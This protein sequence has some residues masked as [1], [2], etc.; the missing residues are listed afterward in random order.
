MKHFFLFFA[1]IVAC[2]VCAGC[3]EGFL[4]PYSPSEYK[5]GEYTL[6]VA[7]YA[8]DKAAV[9]VLTFDD[10]TY[11]QYIHAV[12]ALEER[13]LPGTFFINGTKVLEET[14]PSS[15]APGQK[16]LKD[17]V[18]RGFEVSNHTFHHARLTDISLDSAR[19]EIE[20]N[21]SCIE[22]WTG[23]RPVTFAFPYNARNAK[24]VALAGERRVGVR[25]YETGFGQ[26]YRTTTYQEMVDWAKRAVSDHSIAVAMYHGIEY[27]YD[28][29][30]NPNELMRFWDYLAASEDIWVATFRDASAYRAER[31]DVELVAR[32]ERSQLLIEAKTKL[33]TRLFNYPLTVLVKS[34]DTTMKVK[35][36]P[37]ERVSVD[38][39]TNTR[40]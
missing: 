32:Q 21:D 33:D 5:V 8:D 3:S 18:E 20:M 15:N 19:A 29:W 34:K 9:V 30:N 31:D 26:T 2:A 7:K 14:R 17:M 38:V 36:K 27:G 13:G 1:W 10:G 28:Y 11:E 25:T 4:D 40:Y 39:P 35:V 16:D 37:G 23:V 6:S 22:A 12:P 24:L